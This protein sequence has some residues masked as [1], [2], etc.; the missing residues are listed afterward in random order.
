MR[1][2]R[3]LNGF[4]CMLQGVL[5]ALHAFLQGILIE[6][7]AFCRFLQRILTALH[8]SCKGALLICIHSARD[9][10]GSACIVQGIPI[11]LHV[12]CKKSS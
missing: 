9:P 6:L 1:C 7:H 5:M 2:A 10:D 3:D 12:F 11:D 4:A 8:V